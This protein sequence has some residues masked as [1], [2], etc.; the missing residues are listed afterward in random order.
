M[1]WYDSVFE[2]I[3]MRS[4]S[5]LWYWIALAV[6]WSAVSRWV[7]GGPFDMINRARRQGDGEGEAMTDL[8]DLVRINV[9]R[10]LYITD[11]AGIWIALFGSCAGTALL[12]MAVVYDIEIAQAILLLGGPLVVL[13]FMSIHTSRQ[14]RLSEESDSVLIRR[15]MRHRFITQLV[16]VVAIFFTAMFGMYKNL[17]VGHIAF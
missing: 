11:T 1:N 15:L 4:L 3:D 10:I 12:L 17:Y 9:N 2:V 6:L 14:I 7:L 13:W 8:N 5:N 16:G